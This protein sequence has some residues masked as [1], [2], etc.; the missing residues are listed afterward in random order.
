ML[1]DSIIIF[2][3]DYLGCLVCDTRSL[4]LRLIALLN[5]YRP[6]LINL[7]DRT[8]RIILRDRIMGLIELSLDR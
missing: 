4:K 1:N 5:Y 2:D 3:H 7:L 6:E 8:S